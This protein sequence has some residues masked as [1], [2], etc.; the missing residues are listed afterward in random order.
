MTERKLA[1][2][3]LQDYSRRLVH[4]QEAERENIARELHDEIG[5]ALTAITINLQWMQRAGAVNES[6]QPRINESIEVIED[7]SAACARTIARVT[8]IDAGRSRSTGGAKL[9]HISIFGTNW[10]R[11]VGQGRFCKD[12]QH[13]PHH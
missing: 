10:N 5:Q 8:A 3:A 6:A 11:G 1:Q 9:L 4:A 2:R 12:E 13:R 7:A